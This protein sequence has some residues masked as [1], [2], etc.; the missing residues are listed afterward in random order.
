MHFEAAWSRREA[1]RTDVAG[2]ASFS[3]VT[4]HIG[5][6]SI[7]FAAHLRQV[8]RGSGPLLPVAW[9]WE[10]AAFGSVAHLGD[11]MGKLLSGD[12]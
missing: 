3:K 9:G 1:F 10:W 11:G 2:N 6:L 4:V 8:P 7:P 5:F 12:P